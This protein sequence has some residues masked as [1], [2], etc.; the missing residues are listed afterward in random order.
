MKKVFDE[1][2]MMAYWRP[3]N[4]RDDLVRSKFERQSNAVKEWEYVANRAAKSANS[5][6]KHIFVVNFSFNYDSAGVVYLILPNKI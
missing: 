4:L 5:W 6:M 1:R 2:P 3:R